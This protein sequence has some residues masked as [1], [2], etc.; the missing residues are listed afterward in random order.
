MVISFG[1]Y[2]FSLDGVVLC[3]VPACAGM[4]EE[5]EAGIIKKERGGDDVKNKKKTAKVIL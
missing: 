4:I 2:G 3:W 5:R 1:F